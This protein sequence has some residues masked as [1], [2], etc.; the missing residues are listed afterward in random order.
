MSFIFIPKMSK[1]NVTLDEEMGEDNNNTVKF[2]SS[3]WLWSRH[4]ESDKIEE[5][6]T[7]LK[8]EKDKKKEAERDI[9]KLELDIKHERNKQ[10]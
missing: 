7:Q 4:N 2:E 9:K 5:L 3:K 10:K 8:V 6:K 1:I